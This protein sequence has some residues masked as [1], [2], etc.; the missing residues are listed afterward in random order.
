[1]AVQKVWAFADH[2][3]AIRAVTVYSRLLRERNIKLYLI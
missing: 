2:S 3:I 1:M